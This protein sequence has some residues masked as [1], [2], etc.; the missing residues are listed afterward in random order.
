MIP[1]LEYEQPANGYA[2]SPSMQSVD[3]SPQQPAN[4]FGL[5]RRRTANNGTSSSSH[6]DAYTPSKAKGLARKLDLFPKMERD[7]E[8]R[9]E[10]GGR[11][12]LLCYFIMMVLVMAEV[13]EW[14]RLNGEKLEGIVV[15]TRSVFFTCVMM[16]MLCFSWN[17][18]FMTNSCI[19]ELPMRIIFCVIVQKQILLLLNDDSNIYG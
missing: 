4:N 11:V 18:D 1:G 3:M 8:V 12:T 10:R 14:K 6:E 5:H 15:D 7:Y 2:S 19:F 16:W 9:T 13:W 17:V